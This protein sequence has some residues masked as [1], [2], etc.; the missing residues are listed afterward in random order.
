MQSKSLFPSK[1]NG[2][3]G[4]GRMDENGPLFKVRTIFLHFL[5]TEFC[6]HCVLTTKN[7][8]MTETTGL[9]AGTTAV[10]ELGSNL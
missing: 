9:E 7:S 6:P 1:L 3:E 8:T 5:K 4:G 10:A 2:G